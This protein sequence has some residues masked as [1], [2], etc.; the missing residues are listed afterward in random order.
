MKGITSPK[1]E[2]EYYEKIL[3]FELSPQSQEVLEELIYSP[4]I[5]FGEAVMSRF[6]VANNSLNTDLCYLYNQIISLRSEETLGSLKQISTYITNILPSLSL[7]SI[8]PLLSHA[9]T[10]NYT[11]PICSKKLTEIL[12]Q[13]IEE[14]NFSKL[15]KLSANID[16]DRLEVLK[17]LNLSALESDILNPIFDGYN[18]LKKYFELNAYHSIDEL[19]QLAN[20][21]EVE[22]LEEQREIKQTIVEVLE[23][24]QDKL[25]PDQALRLYKLNLRNHDL[26]A[27]TQR[28]INNP[29]IRFQRKFLYTPI[30]SA[31][32]LGEI[33]EPSFFGSIEIPHQFSSTKVSR[34]E[35]HFLKLVGDQNWKQQVKFGVYS[36]DFF[37]VDRNLVI[38]I[39]GQQH[40]NMKYK[41]DRSMHKQSL[42]LVQTDEQLKKDNIFKIGTERKYLCLLKR[43]LKILSVDSSYLHLAMSDENLSKEISDCLLKII[44]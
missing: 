8:V 12:K 5:T 41:E 19:L 27:L 40:Y 1:L 14:V 24:I 23:S 28:N 20:Y 38:E 26:E 37:D 4:G 2:K 35:M 21:I 18:L 13:K 16:K 10:H 6:N 36:V 29:K 15:E 32:E 42:Y 43:G 33:A 31:I 34:S 9:T 3:R 17:S 7:S 25:Y 39:N 22:N 11:L 44:P 30:I